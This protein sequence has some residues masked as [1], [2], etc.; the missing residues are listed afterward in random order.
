MNNIS[1]CYN[2]SISY[3]SSA[4]IKRKFAFIGFALIFVDIEGEELL[5]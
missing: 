3:K 1:S 2:E 5:L 4:A